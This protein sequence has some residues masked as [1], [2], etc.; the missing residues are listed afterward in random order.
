[1]IDGKKINLGGE[2]FIMPPCNFLGLEK[3]LEISE[4]LPTISDQKEQMSLMAEMVLIPLKRNYPDL[5]LDQ[6]KGLLDPVNV[7]EAIVA[8]VEVSGLKKNLIAA[9]ESR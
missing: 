1:M 6:V 7:H 2:D 4:K 5:T 9:A 8:I 3:Y